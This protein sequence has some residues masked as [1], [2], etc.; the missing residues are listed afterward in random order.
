MKVS[1]G[2]FGGSVGGIFPYVASSIDAILRSELLNEFQ[3]PK[4]ELSQLEPKACVYR[5]F[6]SRRR[7]K[8]TA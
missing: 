1:A 5:K 2:V 4:I 7:S 8:R 6:D 3:V